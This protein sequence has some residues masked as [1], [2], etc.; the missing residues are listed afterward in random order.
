MAAALYG[1]EQV[2]GACELHCGA[3]VRGSAWLHDQRW[4]PVDLR[5]PHAAGLV[6][7]GD[8]RQQHVATET[9]RELLHTGARQRHWLAIAGDRGDVVIDRRRRTQESGPGAT[10]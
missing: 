3:H 2:R 10:D 5:V 1:D 4:M 7:G 6:I 8:A 9:V